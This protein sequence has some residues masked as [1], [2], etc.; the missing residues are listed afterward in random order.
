MR[1]EHPQCVHAVRWQ[2][3]CCGN[4]KSS[5][6]TFNDFPPATQGIVIL[7][8]PGTVLYPGASLFTTLISV[9]I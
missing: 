7:A 1:S 6:F 2:H 9:L 8:Y 4:S 5:A 3:I